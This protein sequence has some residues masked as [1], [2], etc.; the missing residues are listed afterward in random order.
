MDESASHPIV[1]AD[2]QPWYFPKPHLRLRGRFRA[3]RAVA[4]GPLVT[5]D[6]E[7]NQLREAVAD[8]AEAPLLQVM[9]L[10]AYMLVR[11]YELLDG[12]LAELLAFEAGMDWPSQVLAVCNGETAPK[13][14]S[15]GSG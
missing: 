4:F 5:D 10:A 11:N 6:P 1:L 3:G 12:Q 2:G 13:A 9:S 8:N 14:S 7:W 15:G